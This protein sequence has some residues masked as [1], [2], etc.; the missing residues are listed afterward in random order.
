[1]GLNSNMT[2]WFLCQTNDTL[3]T[4]H[5]QFSNHSWVWFLF[6][7]SSMFVFIAASWLQLVSCLGLISLRSQPEFTCLHCSPLPHTLS[8]LETKTLTHHFLYPSINP[9]VNNFPT[10]ICG[11][12]IWK[13]RMEIIFQHRSFVSSPTTRKICCSD[14]KQSWL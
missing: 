13:R 5:C 14:Q 11:E 8:F 6:C 12:K 2:F 10:L 9:P 1:M 4:F 7:M 3:A